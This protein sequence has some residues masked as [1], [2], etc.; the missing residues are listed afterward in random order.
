MTIP[1]W[2]HSR[3]A[4]FEKCKYRA[5]LLHAEKVPEPQRPLPPGKT[6]HANDRGT[7]VHNECELYV[8]GEID[9]MP[10]EAA[11]FYGPEMENMREYYKAGIVSLEGEWGMNRN[12]EP[13]NWNGQWVEDTS[14]EAI[15]SKVAKVLPAYGKAGDTVKVG[16]KVFMW[17]PAWLR[18]KLD[19]LVFPTKHT[20]I[21]I[22]YK[23]GKKF[24]NEVKHGEQLQ[25]YQLVAF[26]RYPELEEVTTELWYLDAD[27]ITSQRYT[28]DQGLRFLKSW[29]KRGNAVTTCDKFPPNPNVFSCKWCMYGPWEGGTGHCEVGI[30]R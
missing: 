21:A 16:K 27:D 18:L 5:F 11:K 29:D 14:G 4:E 28:R 2:S 1:S 20:A 19:A 8:K 6:E 7:R 9:H 26:L 30:R 3:L 13:W 25:L 12:W 22:D 17:V 24:G 10:Q 23:T 15:V